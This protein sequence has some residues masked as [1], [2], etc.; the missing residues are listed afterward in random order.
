MQCAP[1]L[2]YSVIKNVLIASTG[3]QGA[4]VWLWPP[5]SPTRRKIWN[6]PSCQIKGKISVCLQHGA[7]LSVLTLFSGGWH[8]AR[9]IAFL[10]VGGLGVQGAQCRAWQLSHKRS[11]ISSLVLHYL[12]QSWVLHMA[13]FQLQEMPRLA[14][15]SVREKLPERRFWWWGPTFA[16]ATCWWLQECKFCCRVVLLLWVPTWALSPITNGSALNMRQ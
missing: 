12:V 1:S 15:H 16:E 6:G 9:A 11:W 13:A 4:A 10:L 5:C 14:V 3:Q 2:E 7:E 8:H